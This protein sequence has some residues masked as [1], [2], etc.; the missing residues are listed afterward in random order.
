MMRRGMTVI[1]SPWC[2]I[3]R[4]FKAGALKTQFFVDEYDREKSKFNDG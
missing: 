2:K 3:P 1:Q 4:T